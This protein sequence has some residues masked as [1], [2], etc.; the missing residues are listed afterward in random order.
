MT[1]QSNK[2]MA[3]MQVRKSKKQKKNFRAWLCGELEAAGYAPTV[4][5]GFAARNVVVGDPDKAQVL[6]TAHYDTQPVLPI[7][8]FI[9][10]RNLFFFVL[11]Q[12][13]IVLPLFIVLGVVEGL[14][15]SFAPKAVLWWLM[16]L[17]SM[18]IG[19]FFIWWI[20]DGKANRHTANDNTSGVLTLLETALA[21]PPEHRERVCF[22]FF[23][24]EEKGMFGSAAFAKKHKQVKKHTT[25]L[26]FD[27]VSDGDSIQFFPQRKLKKDESALQRIEAAFLPTRG[28]E[29]QVVRGFSMYPSDNANFKRGAGVCALKHKKVIGYYMDR[30]HTNKDTVLDKANIALLRDGALRYIAGLDG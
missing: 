3:E 27:C 4:E 21:L 5:K 1:A 26:N 10:P 14:L 11:Y 15:I 22:V 30:I 6:L 13:A 24:N 12:I 7:P 25:V 28:K 20:M 2:I 29:V 16:P 9:T 8:N 18:G 17:A 23:D 19:V